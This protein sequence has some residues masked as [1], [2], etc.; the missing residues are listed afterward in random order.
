MDALETKAGCKVALIDPKIVNGCLYVDEER[1]VVLGGQVMR[2][3]AARQ[4]MLKKWREPNRPEE[5]P[6]KAPIR[7]RRAR[8][9]RGEGVVRRISIVNIDKR[10][11]HHQY[12]PLLG[13]SNSSHGR[14]NINNSNQNNNGTI[15]MQ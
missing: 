8:R 3:E 4:R 13:N 14:D 15:T 7:E 2:L 6:A 1:L 10:T 5:L 11:K 12:L 9:R